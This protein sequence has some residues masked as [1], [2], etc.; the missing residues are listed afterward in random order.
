[1]I[2]LAIDRYDRLIPFY[3]GT[4][5]VPAGLELK[6]LQIGQ[7]A[8]LR[9]G[10]ER[11]SRMLRDQ[12]FDAAEVSFS[13]YIAACAR[14]APL[15][16]IPV[17]PRRLFSLG[18]VFVNTNSG[19]THPK[20]LA[21]KKVG[22]QSFQTTL[23]VL[24]K[25]DMASEYG[26]DLK[27]VNWFLRSADT[28]DTQYAEGYRTQPLP[29]GETMISALASGKLDAIFY[30]RTPW[31][32]PDPEL[33]IRRLFE[34][35]EAEEARFFKNNGYWPIMHIVA[36]RNSSVE[37][38]P[39]LPR[40]L[41]QAFESSF[42]IAMTY[43]NDPNWSRLAWTK[44]TREREGLGM[45]VNAWAFGV[46]ANR[47][48]VERFIGYSFDQGIIDRRLAVEDLFHPSVHNT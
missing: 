5:E 23:A 48:N 36:I 25:G 35:P 15:T 33:P 2:T 39:E 41:M 8:R 19:I 42:D 32:D 43:I 38:Q 34:D 47:A 4:V 31:T 45:S 24:A 6:V 17:F 40:L 20:E 7:E 29:D 30:S 44:Y 46:E 14:G 16:A 21:G 18:Q 37:A 9:D 27:S 10:N 1:M 12:E 3:D 11:H 26:L 28:V 22:L 13:S